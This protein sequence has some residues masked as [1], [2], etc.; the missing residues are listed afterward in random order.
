MDTGF[1]VQNGR[2]IK[3]TGQDAEIVIPEGVTEIGAHAFEGNKKT[4]SVSMPDTVVRIE[5]DAFKSC[6]KLKEVFFSNRLKEIGSDAF[7]GCKSL[8][9][10]RLPDTLQSLKNGV[11]AGCD[12]LCKITCESEVFVPESNPFN[13]SGAEPTTGIADSEGFLVFAGVLFDYLGNAKDVIVPSGVK[14]IAALCFQNK[15]IKSVVLPETV[16]KIDDYAF[17]QCKKLSS[18]EMPAGIVFGKHVFTDCK[19]L[20]DENGLFI[21]DGTAYAYYGKTDTVNIPEGTKVLAP[22]LFQI[23]YY[24]NPGNKKIQTVNLPDGLEVIGNNAF[25][26]CTLLEN[27]TIPDSV[28][29]IGDSAFCNCVKLKNITMPQNLEILGDGAFFGCKELAGQDGFVTYENAVQDYFGTGRV[30]EIPEGIT[31]IGDGVFA[32]MGIT[33]ISLPATLQKMGAAFFKCEMLSEISIPEGVSVIKKDTFREC[34]GLKKI[35]LPSTLESIEKSAF[36]FCSS[37]ESVLIPKQVK[38]IGE[39]AFCECKSLKNVQ[40]LGS[41]EVLNRD[42]FR[43][44]SSLETVALPEGLKII[45]RYALGACTALTVIEIPESVEEVKSGAFESCTALGKVSGSTDSLL[46][47]SGAFKKCPGLA[48]ENGMTIIGSTLM[49]YDGPGGD[50]IIPEGVTNLAPDVFREGIGPVTKNPRDRKIYRKEGS[51]K[52]ASLPSTLKKIGKHAFAGCVD[53]AEITLPDHLRLIDEGAFSKCRKLTTVFIPASVEQIGKDSFTGCDSLIDIIVDEKNLHYSSF[54]GILFS[55]NKDTLV[56]FPPGRNVEEY[57]VPASVRSIESHAFIDCNS[58]RKI[59][60]PATVEKIG[61]AAFP[62]RKH[63]ATTSILQLKEI[64]VDPK[65]GSGTIGENIFDVC[66]EWIEEPLVYPM[67]PLK[68]VKER[69]AQICLG[70]G[71]CLNADKYTGRYLEEYKEFVKINE[72]ALRKKAIQLKLSEVEN[73]FVS[74]GSGECQP[75]S[76]TRSETKSKKY[77]PDLTIKK[78]S[79]LLKT[80]ILEEAVQ[81]GSVEDLRAVLETYKPFEMTARAL[82]IAARYRGLEFVKEMIEHGACFSYQYSTGLQRKYRMNFATKSGDY[83]SLYYLML[84]PETMDEDYSHTALCGVSAIHILPELKVLDIKD[85]I[86]IMEHLVKSGKEDISPDELLFWSLCRN[87]LTFADKLIA[88]G[89]NLQ[90]QPPSYYSSDR[91]PINYLDVITT[92]SNTIYWNDYV[93]RIASLESQQVLPVMQRFESLAANAGKKL[94]LSQKMVEV[95]KWNDQSLSF[96]MEKMDCSKL[97]RKSLMELAVAQNAI[98]SLGVMAEMGWLNNPAKIEELLTFAQEKKST[99]ALAW[100]MDYKNRTVDI[101]AEKAK[102]EKKMARELMEN[103]DSVS[104]LKKLWSYRKLENG[105]LQITGYKGSEEDIKIPA[106]IG[107]AAVSV[108]GEGKYT[109]VFKNSAQIRTITIPDGIVEIKESAFSACNSLEEVSIPSSVKK[110]GAYAFSRC[111]VLRNVSIPTKAKLE[112]DVF[113]GCSQL[114]DDNGFIVI[115]GLLCGMGRPLKKEETIIVPD[116]V[117]AVIPFVFTHRVGKTEYIKKIILPEGLTEIN[118]NAFSDLKR[119]EEVVLPSS[120]RKIGKRA[121]YNTGLKSLSLPEKL[122]KIGE[123]AFAETFIKEVHIPKSVK[124]IGRCAFSK[125]AKIRDL[126]IPGHNIKFGKN[127]FGSP[128]ELYA[129]NEFFGNK[130]M[131]YVHTPAGSTA[132]EA[133]QQYDNVQIVYDL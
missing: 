8:R 99:D 26:D 80:E 50:V 61:D 32:G 96:A 87:E 25:A 70:L 130:P 53:L 118:E 84:I 73:Y 69:R 90:G 94:V 131:I 68:F 52:S 116:H 123:S 78:P 95:V 11:F 4:M 6:T 93:K 43:N 35:D 106:R 92:G 71:F 51:L 37:L 125:C 17:S 15:N 65:A 30:I 19:A 24:S 28:R 113:Y 72:K 110:V 100:I 132:E 57:E 2:L 33:S 133:V 10:V 127:I 66:D 101:T 63:T 120:M 105:T 83:K 109:H 114:I 89:I 121:F 1:D 59:V 107:K 64:I 103:P 7:R 29:T 88:L 111:D 55:K 42:V 60:I 5:Y 91:P 9:E 119:L 112:N 128:A 54:D 97:N 44:C 102:K 49:K 79:E 27:I 117:T 48:D 13:S 126:Y 14:T 81:K 58:L 40:I 21:Y 22:G 3:Y 124:E 86:D 45:D 47:E 76:E 41:V 115:E 23:D 75:E 39:S 67:L 36:Y 18:I 62:R 16:T 98:A 38:H 82:G 20:A 34:T 74:A 108:I 104:A 129:Y 46:I 12:K 77:Q 122:E 85:R 31:S 56:Y